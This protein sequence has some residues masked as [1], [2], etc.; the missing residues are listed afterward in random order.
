[1]AREPDYDGRA[2]AAALRE[3]G[4]RE[5]DVSFTHSS[6]AMLGIPAFGLDEGAIG[7][8]FLG[9]FRAVLGPDGTLVLPAFT[10]SYTKDEVFDPASTPPTPAMG[11]LPN[12]LWRHPDAVRSLDP[13]FSVIAFGG[14]ARELIAQAGAD[15]CF[16]PRSLYARL[17]ERD[18]AMLNIGIASHSSLIHHVEQ[19]NG[20]PYRSIKRFHGITRVDGEERESEVAYNVRSLEDARHVPDFHRVDR[21][22]RA[23]GILRTARLGRGE[24]NMLRAREVE[25]LV[26]DGLASDPYYLVAGEA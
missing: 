20:V 1:M 21:D 26:L 16:G 23:R 18:A 14:G 6:V 17:L 5:G 9:A 8:A 2:I 15:D 22:A 13:I 10:Y 25:R 3:A 4:L 7:E 24:L 11:T 12:A 19:V